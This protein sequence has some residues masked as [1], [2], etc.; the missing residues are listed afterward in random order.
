VREHAVAELVATLP[1]IDRTM[2]DAQ[3]H[4]P[5]AR[6]PAREHIVAELAATLTTVEHA[7]H[8]TKREESSTGITPSLGHAKD[9]CLQGRPCAIRA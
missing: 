3:R 4:V 5:G 6:H 7:M 8:N 2:Y 1:T 9:F